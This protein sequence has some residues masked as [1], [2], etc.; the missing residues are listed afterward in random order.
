KAVADGE[1]DKNPVLQDAF[2][3]AKANGKRVH[4]IG[5]LSDGGVHAHTRHL[6][7]LCE[8]A[9]HAGLTSDTVF[10]HA[11]L[12]G[13]DTDPNSGI[14]Y[15]TVMEQF[16]DTSV[17]QLAS[18]V[19]RY[20][21]MDRD[22]RWE[23]VKQAYDLLVKGVGTPTTNLSEAIRQSYSERSEEH[24]SELQSRENLVCRL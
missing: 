16:L 5:L 6:K 8:A 14:G 1:F 10:I 3:Y 22:N 20:Y 11:F 15:V 7:G 19:G 23:R 24:T 12:D 13:R 18:A 4:F 9:K 17:G 2:G 21:A